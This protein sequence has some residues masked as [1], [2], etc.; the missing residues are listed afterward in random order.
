MA[1][2]ARAMALN[3][4][5]NHQKNRE[6]RR[7]V[8][9]KARMMSGEGWRDAAI[10][11]VSSRGLMVHSS[12]S[13]DPG[14]PVEIRSGEQAI[15]ARVVWKKGQRIG[16]RSDAP[17]PVMDLV[18]L[19]ESAASASDPAEVA[20]ERR[21]VHRS[22][23]VAPSSWSKMLELA[24]TLV[25]GGCVAAGFVSVGGGKFVSSLSAVALAL[26]R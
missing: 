10:L 1:L 15:R 23:P 16:L 11:N 20:P 24:S 3:D 9:I 5:S 8:R 13:P 26:H 6:W 17:L 14:R 2:Q 19:S 4:P 18:G 21:S 25:I 7:Y 12:C 22:N